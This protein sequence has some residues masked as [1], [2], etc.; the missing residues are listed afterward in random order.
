MTQTMRFPWKDVRDQVLETGMTEGAGAS[1]D[2]LARY[3]ETLR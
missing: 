1:Y 3:L 2:R